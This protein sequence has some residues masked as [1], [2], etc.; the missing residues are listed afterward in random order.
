MALSLGT[1]GAVATTY[2]TP[3]LAPQGLDAAAELETFATPNGVEGSGSGCRY[4]P[5]VS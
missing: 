4:S 3:R 1:H 2:G 5:A